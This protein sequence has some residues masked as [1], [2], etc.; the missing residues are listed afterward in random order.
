MKNNNLIDY[1]SVLIIILIIRFVQCFDYT[2]CNG[3]DG[4]KAC[5]GYRDNVVDLVDI[6]DKH[7]TEE[8]FLEWSGCLE[9]SK[10]DY[11]LSIELTN[12]TPLEEKITMKFNKHDTY[13]IDK[14]KD[15]TFVGTHKITGYYNYISVLKEYSNKAYYSDVGSLSY[16]C[17]DSKSNEEIRFKK[18]VC[19]FGDATSS[20]SIRFYC[21]H[22]MLFMI[23]MMM[24]SKLM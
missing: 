9:P 6:E 11:Y 4:K 19:K 2:N 16:D 10:C 15:S 8:L 18:L 17:I 13:G 23:R 24:L 12:A 1:K 3:K 20:M 22:L 21:Q 5:W 14:L 7:H